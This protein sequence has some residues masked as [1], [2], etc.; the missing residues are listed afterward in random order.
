MALLA[1][2]AGCGTGPT[3]VL[4]E[5]GAVG[6]GGAV[7][8]ATGNAGLGLAAGVGAS[9]AFDEGYAF[10]ERRFYQSKQDSIA[11][12]AG[13]TPPG[14]RA[15]WT[16]KGPFD[17][18][19]SRGRLEVVRRFGEI[20]PC[21]EVVYTVEPLPPERQERAGTYKG[22]GPVT[23]VALDAPLPEEAGVFVTTVCRNPDGAWRWAQSR[24]STARWGA[25]Q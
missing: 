2:L 21:K 18:G 10:A 8:A 7:G 3:D 11:V 4:S 25:I 15:A 23:P 12:V 19:T 13:E 20:A 24:P 5:V 1:P 9:I 16:F 14:E 22:G 17:L 6:V